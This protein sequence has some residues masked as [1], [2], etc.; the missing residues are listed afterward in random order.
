MIHRMLAIAGLLCFLGTTLSAMADERILRPTVLGGDKLGDEEL[1]KAAPKQG[2]ITD[3]ETFKK[4]WNAWRPGEE[5]PEV[6]FEQELI[7]VATH[8]GP[9]RVIILPRLDDEGHLR[10]VNAGTKIAGRGFGYVLVKVPREGIVSVNDVSIEG[11]ES[12]DEHIRVEVKGTLRGGIFAIGGETTGTVINAKG[13][14]WE[15][16]FGEDL[17]LQAAANK[18]NNK[19]VVVT[20]TLS[21]RSGVEIRQRWIVAVKS[22]KAA[23]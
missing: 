5:R 13:A 21:V 3:A 15:L 20:G 23:E 4:V 16:D 6:D 17:D 1:R 12:V 19:K 7:L 22:L 11:G 8:P 10:F 18:L 14:S 2:F 9:N